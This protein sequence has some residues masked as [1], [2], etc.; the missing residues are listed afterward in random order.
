MTIT[1]VDGKLYLDQTGHFPVTSNRGNAYATLFFT[2]DGNYIKSY[3]IKSRHGS[4]LLKAYN[5]VY[6]FLRVRGYRPQLH[7]LDNETSR[8][9]E[10]FIAEQQVKVQ[11]T[12]ADMHCTNIAE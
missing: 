9:V 4:E 5:D 1:E 7:K 11:Y 8:D 3:P 12:P 6:S 2:V 10:D